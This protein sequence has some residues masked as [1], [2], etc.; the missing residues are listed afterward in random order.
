VDLLQLGVF[1]AFALLYLF[2]LPRAWRAWALMIASVL[3][4]YW[5]QPTLNV[6]WLDYSLPTLLLGITVGSWWLSRPDGTPATRQ[7]AVASA[8]VVGLA[9]A[10]TVARYVELPS[11]LQLTSRP[12]EALGVLLAFALAFGSG[13]TVWRVVARTPQGRARLISVA[14]LALVGLFVLVKTEAFAVPL[15]GFLRLQAGNDPALASLR[16]LEWL[17]FSYVAFRLIATLRDRQTGMLPAVSLRDYVA[18]VVFFPSITAGPIARLEAENSFLQDVQSLPDVNGRDP[19]RLT[20]GLTRIA[21]GVFKKFVVADSLALFA[22][23]AQN[24][25]QAQSA[26]ALWV[27]LY[28]YALRLFFDFSGYTDIAIGLAWLLGVRL[29]ENFDRPYLKHNIALFWQSWHKSLSDWVRFYVYS[30]LSRSL[31]RR[32]PKPS[33]EAITL[34][35]NLATMGIIGLWHGVTLPF[36][37]WGVWHGLGLWVHKLWSDRTRK[38]YISLKDKPRQK[39]AW[40]LTGWALTFHFVVLGWVWFTLPNMEI[41]VRV[42]FSLFGLGWE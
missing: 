12:P 2:A 15:A 9:L 26:V 41:A 37:V 1:G 32:K 27:M 3:A 33:T 6:R 8:V 19:Q 18:Y 35:C 29:P 22:L 40:T 11:A 17:G 39:L 42:F 34:I 20:E 24:A 5:L 23:S 28:G 7:D 10:L 13:V 21:V 36:L 14:L 30:P 25:E 38:W 31:L 4:L 16:D